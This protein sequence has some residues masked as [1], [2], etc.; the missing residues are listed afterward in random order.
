[1]FDIQRTCR[2]VY[3]HT[4]RVMY[5]MKEDVLKENVKNFDSDKNVLPPTM[6]ELNNLLSQD[7]HSTT[8]KVSI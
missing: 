6:D 7:C 4:R 1:M 8:C 2:E 3:D 5:Q